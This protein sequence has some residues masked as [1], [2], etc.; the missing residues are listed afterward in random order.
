M[1]AD[2]IALIKRLEDATGPDRELDAEIWWHVDRKAAER[3]YW[4]AALGLPRSLG[5]CLPLPDGLGGMAIR[6]MAPRFTESIDAALK[7]MPKGTQVEGV[8]WPTATVDI[9]VG[10]LY[11]PIAQGDSAIPAIALCIAALRARLES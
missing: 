5:E 7:L 2:V 8:L 9:H 11:D 4:T 6:R 10:H 1:A 3:T